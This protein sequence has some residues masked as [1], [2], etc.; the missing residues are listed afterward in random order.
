MVLKSG[1]SPST[2]L[3]VLVVAHPHLIYDDLVVVY[4]M[5]VHVNKSVLIEVQIFVTIGC[6]DHC[7]G[8]RI[9]CHLLEHVMVRHPLN[10]THVWPRPVLTDILFNYICQASFQLL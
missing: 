10:L 6:A 5:I 2:T 4:D 9:S 8:G 1:S 7:Y 3:N